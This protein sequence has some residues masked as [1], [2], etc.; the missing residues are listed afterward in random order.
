[1]KNKGSTLV[2]ILLGLIFLCA[3]GA[4]GYGYLHFTAIPP[5]GWAGLMILLLM[6]FWAMQIFV[7]KVFRTT[8]KVFLLT[9]GICLLLLFAGSLVQAFLAAVTA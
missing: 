6:L 7:N 4:F 2:Q 5:I 8:T 3:V 9:I 1:M